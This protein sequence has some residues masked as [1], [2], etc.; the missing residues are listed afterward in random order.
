M[1]ENHV[2]DL[3]PLTG[4]MNLQVLMMR[5]NDLNDLSVFRTIFPKLTRTDIL[6]RK[7]G[8]G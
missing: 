5:G 4:L 2:S 1:Y 6:L 8:E 3:T 7:G